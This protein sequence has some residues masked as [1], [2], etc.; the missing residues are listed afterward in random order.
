MGAVDF[1]GVL[2]QAS[3]L[4]V[5]CAKGAE[6]DMNLRFVLKVHDVHEFVA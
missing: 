3:E 2:V 1:V 5:S 6:M 4:Y